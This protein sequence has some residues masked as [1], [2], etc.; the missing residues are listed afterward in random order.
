[1][2]YFVL[3]LVRVRVLVCA[4]SDRSVKLAAACLQLWRRACRYAYMR[5]CNA[6]GCAAWASFL[7]RVR[8]LVCACMR[9]HL[10]SA[11]IAVLNSRG[12]LGSFHAKQLWPLACR[13]ACACVCV[14]AFFMCVYAHAFACLCTRMCVLVRSLKCSVKQRAR[15]VVSVC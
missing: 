13:Y 3:V 6:R 1:M 12:L 2:C 11:A 5:G 9:V 10:S 4:R 7:V 15:A 8:L 14:C